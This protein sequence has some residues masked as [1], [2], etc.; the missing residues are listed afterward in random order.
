MALEAPDHDTF[1]DWIAAIPPSPCERFVDY[2]YGRSASSVVFQNP[3]APQHRN[4]HCTEVAGTNSA[5]FRPT[6]AVLFVVIAQ[7]LSG[8][9]CLASQR[10]DGHD[11]SGID[12]R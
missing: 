7:Q 11:G 10:S 1:A 2:H 8:K 3:S 6:E 9:V 12:A 4:P 5:Y